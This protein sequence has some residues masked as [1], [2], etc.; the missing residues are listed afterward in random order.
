MYQVVGRLV[1]VKRPELLIDAV[2]DHLS[3]R[4]SNQTPMTLF[5]FGRPAPD[6][7]WPLALRRYL[8]ERFA[9][10]QA[11]PGGWLERAAQWVPRIMFV[12]VP[13]YALLLSL[14]YAWRRR[15]F[16][17][18]HLIVSLHFH[19]ALFLAASALSLV[20]GLIGA[21]LAWLVLLFY[22]NI[23]LYRLQRV[24]YGRGR[25][26]SVVRTM[27]LDVLYFF[28]LLFGFL[29]VLLLGALA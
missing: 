10:V 14:T 6:T 26:A 5:A 15:F 28:A 25:F 17:F 27:T 8:G 29:A 21:G 1:D 9:E 13:V 22:S 19:S 4:A 20:S 24:V 18:D 2:T 12:M 16:F 23:Y 11:D 7:I 3:P